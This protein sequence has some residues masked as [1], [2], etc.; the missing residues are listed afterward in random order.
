MQRRHGGHGL[1]TML[2][3]RTDPKNMKEQ[4]RSRI[5]VVGEM[6]S[7]NRPQIVPEAARILRHESFKEQYNER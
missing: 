1:D 7:K 4:W 6:D 3:V 5:A 2:G